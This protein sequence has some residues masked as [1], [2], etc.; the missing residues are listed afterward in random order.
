[1]VI[2][3]FVPKMDWSRLATIIARP[4][5]LDRRNALPLDDLTGNGFEYVGIGGHSAPPRLEP[6]MIPDLT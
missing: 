3:T 4:L 5:I 1:M 2:S 6:A